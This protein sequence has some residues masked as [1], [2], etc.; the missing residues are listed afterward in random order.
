[1]M[2]KPR[3]DRKEHVKVV[4]KLVHDDSSFCGVVYYEFLPPGQ[5]LNKKY[6]LSVMHHMRKAIV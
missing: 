3:L 5:T 4:Q 1:M 6:N 2:L